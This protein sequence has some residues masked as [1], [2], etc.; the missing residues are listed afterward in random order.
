MPPQGKPVQLHP[1]ARVELQ[2]SVNFYRNRGGEHW[3]ERFKQ[4]VAEGLNVIA[5]K[6]E[7]H[8]PE[9]GLAGVQKLRLKQFPFSLIFVNRTD[10]VWVVAIAHGSRRPGYWKNRIPGRGP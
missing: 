9:T 7:G 10:Y 8:P 5:S 2:E 4:R 1:Q 3:A 6:P